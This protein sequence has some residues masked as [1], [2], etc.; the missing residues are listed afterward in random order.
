MSQFYQGVTDSVLPPDV[1]LQF[2]T[3]SGTAVPSL[4]NI[5]IFGG[6]GASTSASGSTIT[7]TVVTTGF[8]WTEQSGPTYNI[9]VENGVFCNASMTVNLPTAGVVTGSSVII[10]NDFGASVIVQ[11]AGGQRIQFGSDISS[12]TGTAISGFQGDVL[13]LIY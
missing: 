9:P 2:T 7:V 1:P 5:N 10:Y 11:A 8:A 12:V 4:H 6:T 3:N 13:E